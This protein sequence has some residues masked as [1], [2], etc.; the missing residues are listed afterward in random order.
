MSKVAG[1]RLGRVM[2][3]RLKAGGQVY[4]HADTPDHAQYWDRYHAVLKSGPGCNFRCGDE[5]VNME[6]GSVWWFQNAL[7]HEVLNNSADD[8][9]H[10]II[11]IRTQ[12]LDF[13][14]LTPTMVELK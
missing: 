5:M 11:D 13:K 4:P 9:I 6:T 14:G 8:R 1:E 3:N 12:R 2:I 10:L 7:E